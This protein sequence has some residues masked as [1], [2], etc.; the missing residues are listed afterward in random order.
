MSCRRIALLLLI[1]LFG[2]VRPAWS[3][4]VTASKTD[5]DKETGTKTV[6]LAEQVRAMRR[7]Y[8]TSLEKL[9]VHY[10][11]VGDN[12]RAREVEKELNKANRIAYDDCPPLS[13]PKGIDKLLDADLLYTQ[14]QK[15][16]DKGSNEDLRC[17]EELLQQLLRK[18]PTS[19]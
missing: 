9:R 17:A 5:S 2:V 7:A 6:E 13:P 18:Y 11:A 1:V 16:K 3:D 15:L 19:E 12:D 8:L 4:D 14:A 10:I